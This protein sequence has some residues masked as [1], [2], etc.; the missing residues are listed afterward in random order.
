MNSR[1]KCSNALTCVCTLGPL[2]S[3]TDGVTTNEAGC[4][5]GA[6]AC[7]P[8]TGLF[9]HGTYNQCS[10]SSISTCSNTEGL[11]ANSITC[12][13]GSKTCNP[14]N[15]LFCVAAQSYCS[16]SSGIFAGSAAPLPAVLFL[17]LILSSFCSHHT[18]SRWR[19]FPTPAASGDVGVRGM[20]G[21]WAAPGGGVGKG[22]SIR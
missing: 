22:D 14:D 13:C 4:I 3:T 16:S 5:C 1:T 9:C 12:V 15:G 17:D 7:T 6:E 2:C 21:R 18:N 8:T 11:F 19:C 10:S 20:R